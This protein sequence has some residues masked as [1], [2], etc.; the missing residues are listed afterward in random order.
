[1][2]AFYVNITLLGDPSVDDVVTALRERQRR[3]FVGVDSDAGAGTGSVIVYDAQADSQDG[4]GLEVAQALTGVLGSSA[5]VVTNHDDDI[6][7][8][9]LVTSGE[10]VDTYNSCP[11]YFTWDGAGDPPPPS[12]GDARALS[13]AT[14]GSADPAAVE[15]ILRADDEEYTFA[16]ERHDALWDALGLPTNG[17]FLGFEYVTAGEAP[18]EVDVRAL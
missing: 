13:D 17:A 5:L 18:P 1:M 7:F 10:L 8:I 11:G 15:R 6:L 4:S 12:G 3:G 14:G 16:S 2:G 9:E